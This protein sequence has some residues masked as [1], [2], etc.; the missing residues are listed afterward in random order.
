[1]AFTKKSLRSHEQ[2]KQRDDIREPILDAASDLRAQKYL[3]ELF[4]CADDQPSDDCT[5]N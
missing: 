3:G 1:M 2:H 4:S 5:G